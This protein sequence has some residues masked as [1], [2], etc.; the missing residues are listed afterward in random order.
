[1]IE[2]ETGYDT[3]EPP[4]ADDSET[5]DN[6]GESNLVRVAER[7][8]TALNY[9]SRYPLWSSAYRCMIPSIHVREVIAAANRRA[10]SSVWRQFLDLLRERFV[11]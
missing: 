2:R 4:E 5:D 3:Y 7:M 11:F 8:P 1:M 9:Q 6:E 10:A